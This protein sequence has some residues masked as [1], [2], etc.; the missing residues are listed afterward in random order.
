MA[1]PAAVDTSVAVAAFGEWHEAHEQAKRIVVRPA[2]LPAHCALETYS[3]L[4]RLPDPFRAPAS[5]VSEFLSRRFGGRWLF[6]DPDSLTGL[7]A[8]LAT[9]GIIGGSSYDALV[10]V[11]ARD[12]DAVLFTLD[13][14]A[15]QTYQRLGIEYRLLDET[16]S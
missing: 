10:A 16:G 13:R 7:V 11:T 9:A 15:E 5:V 1:G 6:P 2:S 4:T 12:H 14:R 3:T 8:R